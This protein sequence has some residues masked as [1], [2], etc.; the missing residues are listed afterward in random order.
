VGRFERLG[1]LPRNWERIIDREWP[2]ADAVGESRA[3]DQFH[4]QRRRAVALLQAVDLCDVGMVQ[5]REDFGFLLK[6]SQSPYI[7]GYRTR[8]NLDGD[9][10]LQICVGRS[11]DLPHTADANLGGDFI[12]AE[13]SARRQSHAAVAFYAIAPE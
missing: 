3:F 13:A 8:K 6:A 2:F 1:N 7:G 9:R 12:W 10:A 11:V 5:G 4:H